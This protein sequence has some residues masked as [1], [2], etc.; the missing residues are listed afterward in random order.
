MPHSR[1]QISMKSTIVIKPFPSLLSINIFNVTFWN[2]MCCPLGAQ[3]MIPCN[4]G[5][6][7]NVYIYSF[8]LSFMF[9][10]GSTS[11][12]SFL[13]SRIFSG[14]KSIYGY[15]KWD[16]LIIQHSK[17]PSTCD[18]SEKWQIRNLR[19]LLLHTRKLT[20]KWEICNYE[21]WLNWTILFHLSLEF[22]FCILHAISLFT[23][24]L[25][26]FSTKFLLYFYW[27]MKRKE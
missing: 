3:E 13:P 18:N 23:Q 4:A 22:S 7:S 15:T 19:W 10:S 17:P 9:S 6:I 16:P 1:V 21:H 26:Y 25:E 12:T 2:G 20:I 5:S 8:G 24:F 11:S 14:M 27:K